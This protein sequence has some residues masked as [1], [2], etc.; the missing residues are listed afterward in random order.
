MFPL[1]QEFDVSGLCKV[2]YYELKSLLIAVFQLVGTENIIK[3]NENLREDLLRYK[4]CRSLE[5]NWNWRVV[6]AG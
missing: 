6:A 5:S 2:A 1:V 3:D 4:V